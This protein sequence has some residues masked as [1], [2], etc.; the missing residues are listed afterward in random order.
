[1][2]IEIDGLEERFDEL[3]TSI[4]YVIRLLKDTDNTRLSKEWYS[5]K[6]CAELK[7]VSYEKLRHSP[8]HLWPNAGNPTPV[9]SEGRYSKLYRREDVIVWLPKT[10]AELDSEYRRS[11]LAG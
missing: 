11:V 4:E 1:M 6:D 7:G 9:Y 5:L 10:E 2:T 8:K 3:R